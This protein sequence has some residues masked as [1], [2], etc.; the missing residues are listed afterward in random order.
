MQSEG[1]GGGGQEVDCQ[2]QNYCCR[3]FNVQ[4]SSDSIF[5]CYCT[6]HS[7]TIAKNNTIRTFITT[8]KVI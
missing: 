5:F 4:L 2:T 7:I 3:K 1:G 6:A 8:Y